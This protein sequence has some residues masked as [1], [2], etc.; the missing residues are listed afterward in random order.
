[1]GKLAAKLCED[2]IGPLLHENDSECH[3]EVL[4]DAMIVLGCC[5]KEIGRIPGIL[6]AMM[7]LIV[8]LKEHKNEVEDLLVEDPTFASEILQELKSR[9]KSN[10]KIS[11]NQ[12]SRSESTPPGTGSK[13]PLVP[14]TSSKTP[15]AAEV[16]QDVLQED[17]PTV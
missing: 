6:S 7:P 10:N 11:R 5:T 17:E 12:N 14:G 9:S 15:L 13:T 2:C 3:S 4:R 1:M 8:E 16:L